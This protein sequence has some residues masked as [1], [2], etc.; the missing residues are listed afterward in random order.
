MGFSNTVDFQEL[1]NIGN[2]VVLH[3]HSALLVAYSLLVAIR[4]LLESLSYQDVTQF[5]LPED[6]KSALTTPTLFDRKIMETIE[7]TETNIDELLK[8]VKKWEN[9]VGLIIHDNVDLYD[10]QESSEV[11]AKVYPYFTFSIRNPRSGDARIVWEKLCAIIAESRRTLNIYVDTEVWRKLMKIKNEMLESKE[12]E[13]LTKRVFLSAPVL[14]PL[15]LMDGVEDIL[16]GEYNEWIYP[17][18][19]LYGLLSL[20]GIIASPM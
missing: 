2:Q 20:L 17:Y 14:T 13:Y 15:R 16:N 18:L 3:K 11:S 8:K 9:S 5:S 12:I 4:S 7:K 6:I 1:D 10:F 19:E